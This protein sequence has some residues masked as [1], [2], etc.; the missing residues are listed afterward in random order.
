MKPT[1][2][3]TATVTEQKSMRETNGCI[4]FIFQVY[5]SI[6]IKATNIVK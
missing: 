2:A 1:F 5:I 3:S 6:Y 4:V